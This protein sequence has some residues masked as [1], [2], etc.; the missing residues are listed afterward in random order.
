MNIPIYILNY[1]NEER[2][3]RMK[4]RFKNT[5]ITF[6]EGVN[7]DEIEYKISKETAHNWNIMLSHLDNIKKFYYDTDA[8]YAIICE[9]DIYVHKNL[10]ELLPEIIEQFQVLK[11]DILL[12]SYLLA[13]HPKNFC[14]LINVKNNHEYYTYPARLW[15]AHMYLISRSYAKHLIEKYTL[16]WGLSNSDKSF[17]PD[18]IITKNGNRAMIWP[19][20]GVEEGDANTDHKRQT[21]FHKNCRK[22][23]YNKD[24][25]I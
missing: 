24:V 10:K 4:N 18:W 12:L 15:G 22:F 2:R 19:P 7:I 6:N 9:D 3:E 13:A 5:N 14:Q 16:E 17:S 8:S 1:K 23:L 25:Y 20:L 21:E 11:L